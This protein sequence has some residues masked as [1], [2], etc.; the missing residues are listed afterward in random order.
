MKTIRLLAWVGVLS[1]S[2]ISVNAQQQGG[3]NAEPRVSL[4]E[5]A[6]ALDASGATA[7]EGTL[8]TT[9][10]NG[11]PD[12]PVTNIRLVVKNVS[13]LFLSYASGIVT[14]YDSSGI[15]CGEGLFKAD[16]LAV[17]E[18]VE[19]DTPGI[20]IRCT[21]SSW[22]IVATNLVPRITANISIPGEAVPAVVISS[23]LLISVDGEEHPIQLNRPM[24]LTL[25][26]SKRTIIVRQSP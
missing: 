19:T 16:A 6:L 9:A 8:R 2:L 24:V 10:L 14:F 11:A 22:R 12:T 7:L 5:A 26:D 23:S 21:P 20:R 13:Q 3:S 17:N 18:S 25:G 15:R 4:S 1:F